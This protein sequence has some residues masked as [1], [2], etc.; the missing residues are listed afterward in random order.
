MNREPLITT[1]GD[2]CS[3]DSSVSIIIPTR[4]RCA[5]LAL[6]LT[7][8]PA[9]ALG[10]ASLEVIVVDDCS[11]DN[12][13]KTVDEFRNA[14]GWK[15]L[16]LRQEHPRRAN[17]ARNAALRV[18]GGEIIVLIDDDVLVTEGWLCKLLAG[19]S[20]ECPVVSGPVQL[21]LEGSIVGRHREE[22]SSCLSEI[23][24]PPHGWRGE[25]V[26]VACN[27]AAHRSVFDRARF[28]ESVRPPVEENDWLERAGVHAGFVQDALVWH[29]KTREEAN[30]RRI[31]AGSWRG[32]SEGGWWLRERIKIPAAERRSLTKRSLQTSLRAFGHA[33][34]Q[35]C[36]GGAVIGLGELSR[37]LAL[38]GLIKRR[39]APQSWR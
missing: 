19:L 37:A 32:G 13:R 6:C 27:M 28:D 12:T 26:P 8:L 20:E 16:Y 9:G 14:S 23:L 30:L 29:H 31:L 15:V 35:G 4:N 22:I 1:T 11:S 17:A 2:T 24:S 3:A 38:A 10:V 25:I 36:W 5:V 39:R 34:I 7:A 33:A 21:A 18:A